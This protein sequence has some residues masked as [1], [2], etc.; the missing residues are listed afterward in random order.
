[1]QSLALRLRSL[2]RPL[3][4]SA[5]VLF[6]FTA[7]V[8]STA[9]GGGGTPAFV[10]S[11][12][13]TNLVY[14]STP[15][16][17][18]T[19][20]PIVPNTVT[21]DGDPATSWQCVPPLPDGLILGTDG[22]ISGT[23]TIPAAATDH[24]VTASNAAGQGSVTINVEVQ[25]SESKSLAPKASPTD[26][27]LRHFLDRTH[28]GF[29]QAHYD[30]L[31]AQGLPAYVDAMT[32]FA[33]TTTLEND[34]AVLYLQDASDPTGEFPSE[35]DLARWWLHMI[36]VNPNPFQENLAFKLH[37][38]FAASTTVLGG[39]ARRFFV[40]HV[41][42]WRHGGAGN[43]RQLLIDMAL[44]SAMLVWLDSVNNSIRNPGVD[45]P[46]ENFS[47]EF[48]ELFCLG[49]DIEYTQADIVE[50]ARAFTGYRLRYDSVTRLNSTEFDWQRHDET[51]K[52]VLGQ[53]IPAQA[54]GDTESDDFA[55]MVD[56]VLTT[57]EA[58]TGVNRVGQWVMRSLL[59]Y[60]C[61]ENPPQNVVDELADQLRT[62]GWELKPVLMTLFQSEA[63]YSAA[64]RE[65]FVKGPVEH[66]AGFM[67]ATNLVGSPGN[68]DSDLELMGHRPTQPPT[69]DGWPG[70]TQWLSAQG[71]VDRANILHRVTEEERALQGSLNIAALDLLPAPNADAGAAVD[72]MAL[73]LN[74]PLTPAER[75]E[76]VTFLDTQ[77]DR[78]GTVTPDPFDPQADRTTAEDRLRN[79]LWILGQHPTYQIR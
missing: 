44:D 63:F 79:L 36:M 37:D 9:C 73:R 26:A 30:A 32:T 61:Y 76:L 68:L 49:V 64:A 24:V 20:D 53:T 11:N 29:S 34:A 78:D 45:E 59:E 18:R 1:M 33:D 23:P 67:R 43:L 77:R 3:G 4:L 5:A 70:G 12:A 72:A 19:D 13:P 58:G 57:D 54:S 10:A 69:V 66:I 8:V 42:L 21:H 15:V 14:T 6:L 25:W 27:D 55:A 41:N 35:D 47:R 16:L 60:F 40:D 22:S 52:T 2:N 17:Y 75:T 51:A 28:F 7:A 46:N 74:V 50:A 56:I 62:A 31:I 65:Q 48:F 39:G 38:H 71:M